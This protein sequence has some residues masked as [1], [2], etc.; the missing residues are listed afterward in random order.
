VDGIRQVVNIAAANPD[1]AII[2]QWTGGRA[3]GHHS[4]EDFH[5]PILA[6]YSSIRRHDNIALVAGSGFGGSD[7]TWPYLTGDWSKQFGVEPMPFDGFLFASRVMVAKEAHTSPSVKDLIVAA[8]GVDDSQWEGTYVKDTGGIITVRSELGEPIHKVN[9]RA[10][11][12]WKEYDDTVF[13]LPREKRAAWLQEHRAEVIQRL[14]ADYFKPWFPAKKDGRVV[15]DLGDMTYE[16]TV[17]R[18]VRLMYVT[19]EDRWLDLSLRN[20]AGDWLRRVEERFAGV[21]GSGPKASKLQ[22]YSSLDEPSAFIT[23][24]FEKYPLATKQLLAHEDKSYFLN[25]AQRSGQKPAP[26]IPILDN[27]FEVWFKKVQRF[28]MVFEDNSTHS[29]YYRIL[30]GRRRISKLSSTKI[31]SAWLSSRAPSQCVI[32]SKRTSLLRR[33]WITSCLVSRQ[34]YWSATMVATRARSLQSTT[35]V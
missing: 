35:W 23:S 31:L 19:H 28:C 15:E 33:C 6:T 14:N 30:S 18:L 29:F 34:K 11:K 32:P 25:I 8:A 2:M 22:S 24:F 3:G 17:L 16:E 7:D 20:L 10:L 1:F 4:F 9:N 21:N 13:K 27:N 26:F 5:Q 12:L